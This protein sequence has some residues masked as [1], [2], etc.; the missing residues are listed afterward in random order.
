MLSSPAFCRNTYA[1]PAP[2]A[3]L[4]WRDLLSTY[5]SLLFKRRCDCGQCANAALWDDLESLTSPLAAMWRGVP[6]EG[7]H[8]SILMLVSPAGV[9]H[10]DVNLPLIRCTMHWSRA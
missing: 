10:S 3:A 1:M 8:T 5:G 7:L 4:D 9:A 2:P 6:A